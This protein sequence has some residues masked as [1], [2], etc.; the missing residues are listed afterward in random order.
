MR[1]PQGIC[2]IPGTPS[3]LGE[4]V[5]E[6]RWEEKLEGM[7]EGPDTGFNLSRSRFPV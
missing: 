6:D 4:W 3:H 5:S 7:G 1:C 2:G